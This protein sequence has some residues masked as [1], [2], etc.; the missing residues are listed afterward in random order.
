MERNVGIRQCLLFFSLFLFSSCLATQRDISSLNRQIAALNTRL[1]E[2]EGGTETRLSGALDS[3]RENQ[4]EM[5]A[6]IDGMRGQMQDLSGRVEDNRQLVRRAVE[7]DTIE[8]DIMRAALPDLNLRVTKLE[9]N[10]RQVHGYLGLELISEILES[11]PE[12]QSPEPDLAPQD[13]P[14]IA[15]TAV[16]P[17]E[18]LYNSILAVY[19]EGRYEQAISDFKSFLKRYPGSA[20]ADNAQFWIGECYMSLKHY[21]QAILAYQEVIKNHPKGNKVPNAMLRQAIAFYEIDDKTS[22]RLLLKK[23]VKKYPDSSEA[24]IAKTR[25]KTIK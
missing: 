17:E 22:S 11:G 23:I 8:Q 6:E 12:S 4:A 3:V 13:A 19:K 25:L 9:T 21:E 1:N 15:E 24:T 2:I 7:R 5:G 16:S 20:L 10:S 18:E 14:G